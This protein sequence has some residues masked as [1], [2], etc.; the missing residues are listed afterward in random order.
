MKRIILISFLFLTLLILNNS[1]AATNADYCQVPP[2]V[3]QNVPASIMIVVDNSGSMFNFAYSDGFETTTTGDDNNCSAS[4]SPCT[5]FT[6]P[7]AYPTYYKYYGYFDPDYWYT[8]TSNRFITTAPK[9]GSGI[10]G[11]RAKAAS[12]W[13]GNFLNWV[14][15]RRVDVLRKVLTG[16]KTTSGEGSGYD[17]LIGEKADCDSRGKYKQIANADLYTPYSGT[18]KLYVN[19][20]NA[21]C[22]GGG[23]G[24][25]DFD[26][27]NST[28]TGNETAQPFNVAARVPSPVEGALQ[29]VVGTKARLGL[30]FYNTNEGGF[31]QVA[32]GGT[33][34]SSTINQINLTR[35]STNTPLAET[36]WSVAG[37]FAQVDRFQGYSS[38]PGPRYSGGDYTINN[39]ND[40]YNYGSG[41]QGRWPS[42][43]KSFV[44]LITDGEPCSD[45]NLPTSTI[46]NY[47]QGRSSFNCGDPNATNSCP[48]V[49]ATAPETYSFSASTFPSC[50]AGNTVAGLE[51]VALWAHTKDLRNYNT[52]GGTSN[53]GNIS[54]TQNLTLYVINAFGKGSTFLR[55]A[56]I[57][58]GFEDSNSDN[59]PDLQSEWDKDGDGVPDTFYEA[60]GGYELENSLRNALSTM[61]KR[62]S[63]G[64]AASV[65]AS[66]E[67]SGANLIQAVFY[68][69]RRFGNDV[70][71]WTGY[72]QNLW[73]YVDPFFANSSIREDTLQETPY[74]KLNLIDDYIAQL[75]FDTTSQTT[76]ARRYKDTDGDGDADTTQTTVAIE[77]LGNVWEAGNLLWS[78]DVTV[79]ATKRKIYTTINGT[80]F[81]SGNFS[82]DTLNGDADNSATLLPY[83]DLPTSGD[84][85]A[86]GWI[87][88]DLNHDA[89][90]NATDAVTL[91]KYIHGEDI[92]EDTTVPADGALDVFYQRQRTVTISGTTHVWKL[93]DILNST[94]KIASWPPLNTYNTTYS[95]TTYQS[96]VDASAYA[97][98]GMVFA[99]GNDGMLHA[100]K[101]GRLELPNDSRADTCTFGT[102]DKA[103]LSNPTGYLG[104]SS[105]PLGHEMWAFIPK[106]VLP[107][108]RYILDTDYCHIYSV[109]LTPYI[110]DASINIDTA[111]P[112]QLAAC[113]NTAYSDYWKCKKS[114]NNWRTILIGG[115]RTGGACR[116]TGVACNSG[117]DCVNT[118]KTDPSD[119]TQ[120]L[121]YSSYFAL[122]ITDQNNPQLLWEFSDP[123]LGFATT[124]PA[125]VRIKSRTAGVTTSTPD[126]DTN[127]RWFV[128]FGSGPTGPV[129]SGDSQF[130]GRSDQNMKL[131]VLDLKT[132]VIATTAPIDTGITYAFAGSMLNATHDSDTDYQDDAVYIP[133]VKKCTATNDICT[134]DGTS[135]TNGGISRLLTK[136]DLDGNDVS[137]IGST[138][139]NPNN[140]AWNRVIDNVGPVTSAVA[141]LEKKSAGLMWLYF[142]T[143]RYS[144][145]QGSAVDDADTRRMLFGIKDPCFSTSGFD[146][147]C[148]TLRTFCATPCTN[149]S[150]CTEPLPCGELTN[151]TNVANTP[152]NPE[153]SSFKG[154]Y[155]NLE[156]SGSYTYSPDAARNFKAER[157][158]TDPLATSSGVVF[159][160]TFKPYSDECDIGGKSFIWAV[161]YST[162]GSAGSLLKGKAVIQTGP[163]VI[164]QV[165]LPTAFSEAGG[166][167]TTA[168]EGV[169]PTAQGL[170]II[171]PPP[172][173]KRILHIRER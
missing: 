144:F 156:G 108:L 160:T 90:V 136:E 83:F 53:S 70:I 21:G 119:S 145:V 149:P 79:A 80:S 36:L 171:S 131:F 65:L 146:T 20:A 15:M 56:A 111:A 64:T 113:S 9:T 66:G 162:G 166:R 77:D 85:N 130:L 133:Y 150:A 28:D 57:N 59:L 100:F 155:I 43:S 98:R 51:D 2:Y 88:G 87:D 147:N 68:P 105:V 116:K 154:W 58:G 157:V 121:G 120:G 170:S 168:L 96:F 109:D 42:C 74:R 126:A 31:V 102:N 164:E 61:L 75:Y 104:G 11:E 132:G 158:I 26:V 30:T 62:A 127:G 44:L 94:S 107:Y 89:A 8:Y 22:G 16:G 91:I 32:V 78:R 5:G 114:V 112:G 3:I 40:P 142:G 122:D 34:L 115:M 153:D 128:V 129:S 148:T 55:Y 165:D 17:R 167:R 161:K 106:N 143:G 125:V 117:T 135:W 33:S 54:G 60:Y 12:E 25:S 99:G 163:G 37:Y 81:L 4:G 6:N 141:R 69:S 29:N 48:A 138:A 118:P 39:N 82:K 7:G 18:R 52:L 24:T 50:G 140:W 14:A 46:L 169:P 124:G 76:K 1:Y 137:S 73:Y 103:C 134:N 47:A 152:S 41:G 19:T 10:T 67:G 97:N 159:F 35:P 86:D 172:P 49:T 23:S 173:V 71:N 45:G 92:G 110:F 101:L 27:R 139:L 63:S 72:L 38:G 13:D 151:V 95:D 93:G 123:A 84:V